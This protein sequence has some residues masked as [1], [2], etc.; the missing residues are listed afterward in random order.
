MG[1][2]AHWLLVIVR[3]VGFHGHG[4]GGYMVLNTQH[5]NSLSHLSTVT[6]LACTVHRL[7]I[8]LM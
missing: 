1:G 2:K 5:M 3:I 8:I 6:I 7:L 4:V